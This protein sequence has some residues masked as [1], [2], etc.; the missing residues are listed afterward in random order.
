MTNYRKQNLFTIIE[1]LA[2]MTI[3]VILAAIT[4]GVYSYIRTKT[5]NDKTMATIKKVEMAMRSFKQDNGYYVQQATQG[6]LT[7]NTSDNDFYTYLDYS[8]MLESGE[9]NSSNN[10]VDAW[11]R[12]ILYQCPGSHNRTMFDLISIGKDGTNNDGSGDD[13]T[14]FTNY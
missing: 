8:K 4:V 3:I 10:L 9:I 7:I 12:E 2:A 5:Y 1:L 11:G 13:I 14:N 6:G